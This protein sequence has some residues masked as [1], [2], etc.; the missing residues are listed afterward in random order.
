MTHSSEYFLAPFSIR[1]GANIYGLIF[2]SNNPVGMEKYLDAA[3]SLDKN[4]GEA[5]FN[6]DN[7]KI[8]SGQLSF[9]PEDNV[10][11]KV[12]IFERNLLQWLKEERTNEEVYLFTLM[13][14]MRKTHTTEILKGNISCLK[15]TSADKIRNSY[16]YL[17]YKP[18]KHI[19]IKNNE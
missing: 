17:G 11:K 3:W 2:G 12:D 4:T 13:N 6:I 8:L 16:F 10:V 19:K 14:G 18:E 9:F 5:N 15:I 1:K 7:D